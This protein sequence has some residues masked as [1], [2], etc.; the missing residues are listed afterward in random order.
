MMD[1]DDSLQAQAPAVITGISQGNP[2]VFQTES[3]HNLK[4]YDLVVI[5]NVQGMVEVNERIYMVTAVPSSKSFSTGVNTAS[6]TTYTSGG[7]VGHRGKTLQTAQKL[8]QRITN[9]SWHDERAMTPIGPDGFDQCYGENH[10]TDNTGLPERYYFGKSYNGTGGE[11]NQIIWNPSS[12]DNYKLRYWFEARASRLVNDS[13]VPLLPPQ[14]HPMIVAGAAARLAEYNVMVDNPKVW[15]GI[16][17]N[18]LEAMKTLNTDF[19]DKAN[20]ED[21][22]GPWLL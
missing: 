5:N 17:S 15:S 13:D 20:Q 18:Q 9:V 19:W 6:Y 4:A 16:Y 22:G 10:W 3:D 1:L 11:T 7:V 8:V 2:G 14:F 12:D 21:L